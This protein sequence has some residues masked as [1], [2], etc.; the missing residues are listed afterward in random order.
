[1]TNKEMSSR[2]NEFFHNE[3]QPDVVENL[4]ADLLT[5]ANDADWNDAMGELWQSTTAATLPDDVVDD[6][7]A[8]VRERIAR[9]GNVVPMRPRSRFR[10]M[11]RWA[12]MW[13]LPIVTVALLAVLAV[14][15]FNLRSKLD[16]PITYSNYYAPLG[17]NRQFVLPDQTHVWLHGGSTLVIASNFNDN[18]RRVYLSGEG[19]FKVAHNKDKQFVVSSANLEMKVLGTEFNVSAYPEDENIITTLEKGSLQV[20]N[21]LNNTSVILKPGDMVAYSNVNGK[22][23]CNRV[24]TSDYSSWRYG[25]IFFNNIK[26]SDL[27]V[28][29]ERS[30]GVQFVGQMDA[31]YLNQRIRARFNKDE[32]LTNILNIVHMLVPQFQ[33]KMKGDVVYVN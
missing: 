23:K 24:Q 18:E 16:R 33:Y 20:L 29:L 31:E 3:Q 4:H 21:K 11:A 9:L 12:A 30:H 14:D 28:K 13:I 6:A 25:Y 10:Q 2:L 22:F 5:H 32:S 17:T 26:V 27:L 1:M 8:R 19:F 15:D 7:Y